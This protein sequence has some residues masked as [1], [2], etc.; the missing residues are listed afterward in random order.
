MREAEELQR[1]LYSRYRDPFVALN[2]MRTAGFKNVEARIV[3]GAHTFSSVDNFIDSW[4]YLGHDE[5]EFLEMHSKDRL[6]MNKE[7][8]N[9]FQPFRS[10]QSITDEFE[11][12]YITG[13]KQ[14]A[15]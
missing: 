13:L 2:T 14:R 1:N 15:T 9:A 4:F 8:E 3:Y 5:P 6:A 10:D 7:L 11:T 12:V